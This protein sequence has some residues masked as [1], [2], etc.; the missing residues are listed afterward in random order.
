MHPLDA[1]TD[2]VARLARPGGRLVLDEFAWD[3]A[4]QATI[5]WFYDI[6][7][8]LAAAGVA[9]PPAGGADLEGRWRSQHVRDGALCNGGDAMVGA[10][11][12]RF[13][14]VSVRRVPYL[15][16][17][18]VPGRD[19]PRVFAELARIEREHLADGTLSATGFRLAAR[20]Q[21]T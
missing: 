1:V 21:P 9:D 17:H 11:S 8:V 20:K 13:G 4:D 12:A 15:A 10:V 16:R 14:D 19:N 2:R 18:L 6:A 7:A 5:R 3:W